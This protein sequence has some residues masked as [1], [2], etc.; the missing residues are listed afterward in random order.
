[1][2]TSSRN[3][4]TLAGTLWGL[5]LA[6]LPGALAFDG[7]ALS[8]F[9]L[10]A[11]LLFAIGGAVGALVAGRWAAQKLAGS[12]LTWA[13]ASRIGAMQGVIAAAIA[14]PSIWLALTVT[15]TGFSPVVPGRILVLF[16]DPG[17][18]L[19]SALAALVIFV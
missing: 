19:Q 13:T 4:L 3:R 6:L 18:F 14:A 5:S 7:L 17:I 12:G 9:L 15:M 11:L 2:S 1:M 8:P 10:A 16:G